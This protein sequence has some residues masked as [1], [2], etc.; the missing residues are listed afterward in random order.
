MQGKHH[1]ICIIFLTH[2]VLNLLYLFLVL[3]THLAVLRANSRFCAQGS[4][5]AGVEKPYRAS[6]IRCMPSKWFTLCTLQMQVRILLIV[7]NYASLKISEF[8]TGEIVQWWVLVAL[9]PIWPLSPL[10]SDA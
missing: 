9:Y 10:K 4:P 3:K 2:K 7:A 8:G 5:L 1:N 6:G